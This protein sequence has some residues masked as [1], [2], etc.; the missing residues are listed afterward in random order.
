MQ[1]VPI[2]TI[3]SHLICKPKLASHPTNLP[4]S[5]CPWALKGL[6][7]QDLLPGTVPGIRCLSCGTT[8][9]V[10]SVLSG[11]KMALCGQR[12]LHFHCPRRGFIPWWGNEFPASQAVWS[13]REKVT[14]GLTKNKHHSLMLS[15]ARSPPPNFRKT[16]HFLFCRSPGTARTPV[17]CYFSDYTEIKNPR[18]G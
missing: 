5:L 9:I 6:H 3:S 2:I 10:P 13:K 7:L 18:V 15:Y 12:T 16:V 1:E 14:S 17:V 11:Y 4:A 8:A